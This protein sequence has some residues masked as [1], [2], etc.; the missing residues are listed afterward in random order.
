MNRGLYNSA[1]AIFTLT[2]N[3]NVKAQNITNSNTVGYKYDNYT[4]KTFEEVFL[5]YKNQDL[6]KLPSKIGVESVDTVYTQGSFMA[7]DRQLDLAIGGTGFFKVDLGNGEIAYTRNGSF[8][9]DVNGNLTD[10]N[11][12][13]VIGENGKVQIPSLKNLSITRDGKIYSG[14]KYIDKINTYDLEDPKKR[15]NSYY[16][17][18]NENLSSSEIN[19]GYLESSNTDVGKELSDV[20]VIQRHMTSN[21]KMIQAQDELNKRIID[22]LAK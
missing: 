17:A 20:I 7:T 15:G 16:V 5:S 2:K 18:K 10:D 14:E 13:Y 3:M 4:N 22:E 6:G 9:I 12:H 1:S 21:H 11:G 8:K 19:Q